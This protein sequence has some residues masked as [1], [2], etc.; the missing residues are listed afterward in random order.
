MSESELNN[1]KQQAPKKPRRRRKELL[2]EET[3]LFKEEKARLKSESLSEEELRESA[4]RLLVA[5]KD[6][7]DASKIAMKTSDKLTF[8]LNA[9]YSELLEERKAIEAKFEKLERSFL[10]RILLK[11][12]KS[13]D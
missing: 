1:E 12:E 3:A 11:K 10:G 4:E 7:I 9:N 8:N 6:L 5:Y 2:G 13:R